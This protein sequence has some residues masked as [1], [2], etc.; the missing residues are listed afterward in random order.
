MRFVAEL[1]R[2]NQM[3]MISVPDFTGVS[4]SAGPPLPEKTAEAGQQATNK[5]R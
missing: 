1:P 5:N 3:L 4:L 2:P